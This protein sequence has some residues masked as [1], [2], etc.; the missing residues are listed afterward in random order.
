MPPSLGRYPGIDFPIDEAAR[1]ADP[2]LGVR[3][4]RLALLALLNRRANKALCAN[5]PA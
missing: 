3:S 2:N 1:R 5:V 4:E